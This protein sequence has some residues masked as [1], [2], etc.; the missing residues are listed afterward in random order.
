MASLRRVHGSHSLGHP[1]P[2]GRVEMRTPKKCYPIQ[3][4]RSL[5][6]ASRWSLPLTAAGDGGHRRGR[7]QLCARGA[8]IA[9][10]R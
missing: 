4:V 7:P 8:S 9:L 5:T 10:W 1:V 2:G 6:V 3:R